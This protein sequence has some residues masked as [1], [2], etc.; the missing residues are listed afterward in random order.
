MRSYRFLS[1]ELH[2]LFNGGHGRMHQSRQAGA[3]N[4]TDGYV[5]GDA[6]AVSL[7]AALGSQ[8][9][10]LGKAEHGIERYL[11]PEEILHRLLTGVH[12]H[13]GFHDAPERKVEL[14]QGIPVGTDALVRVLDVG[15]SRQMDDALPSPTNEVLHHEECTHVVVYLHPRDRNA[16]DSPVEEYQRDARF[17][18]LLV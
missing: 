5:V 7:Q 6:D 2:R 12:A 10:I 1:H 18:Q 4:T 15:R 8:G 17:E 14:L 3:G 16:V 9:G 11:L 13:A